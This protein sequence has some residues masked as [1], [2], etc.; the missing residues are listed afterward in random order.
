[1]L[2]RGGTWCHVV[3]CGVTW[4][5]VVSCGVVMW[6]GV[7][8]R[9]GVVVWCGVTWWCGGVVVWCGVVWCHVVWCAVLC[10][11]VVWCAVLLSSVSSAPAEDELT[12]ERQK[13]LTAPHDDDTLFDNLCRRLPDVSY[14]K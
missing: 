9:G 5:H 8:S 4:C 11:G 7:V 6:C 3:W 14:G 2:C 12:R 10:C 13:L 1:M